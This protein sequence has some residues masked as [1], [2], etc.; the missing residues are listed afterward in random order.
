MRD[1]ETCDAVARVFGKAERREHI[2]HV[3]GFKKLQATKFDEGNVAAGQLEFERV[4]MVRGAEQ[5]SLRFECEAGLSILQHA[6]D[7][8]A[9]LISLIAHRDKLR[10]HRRFA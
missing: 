6:I 8:I 10:A 2:L 7:H 1:A 9:R 3:R 4:G 5:H